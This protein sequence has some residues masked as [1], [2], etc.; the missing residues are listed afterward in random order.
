MDI[1]HV[2]GKAKHW[3]K[4]DHASLFKIKKKFLYVFIFVHSYKNKTN[5]TDTS[6]S[7]PTQITS[8]NLTS[9]RPDTY[10][11]NDWLIGSLARHDS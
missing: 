7:K 8:L 3:P 2:C 1:P 9:C 4:I 11:D 10:V 5:A 6:T